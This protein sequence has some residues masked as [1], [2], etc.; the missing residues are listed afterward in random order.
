M[1][2]SPPGSSVMGLSRQEYW[3]GLPCPPPGVLSDPGIKPESSAL[4]ADSLSLNHQG[5][6][7]TEHNLCQFSSNSLIMTILKLSPVK[8]ACWPHGDELILPRWCNYRKGLC[9]SS[10][11]ERCRLILPF[12]NMRCGEGD[13]DLAAPNVP[14]WIRMHWSWR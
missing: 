2:G 4:Q 13:E 9:L 11:S 14:L 12:Q 1:H 10:P 6:S 3:S 8:A 7:L 5:N